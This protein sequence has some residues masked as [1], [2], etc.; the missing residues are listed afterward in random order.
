ML[1]DVAAAT[2]TFKVLQPVVELVTVPVMH[3]ASVWTSTPNART[4][5]N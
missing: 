2:Q 3:V 5:R 4:R 1:A